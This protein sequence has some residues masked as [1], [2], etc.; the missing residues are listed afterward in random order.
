MINGINSTD[1]TNGINH[2]ICITVRPPRGRAAPRA[3]VREHLRTTVE[4]PELL[5]S[6][7][8][9]LLLSLSICIV[10]IC[11]IHV[12]YIIVLIYVIYIIYIIY[13][14]VLILRG[15]DSGFVR[16]STG[17]NGRQH[18]VT[19]TYRKLVVCLQ[20]SPKGS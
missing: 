10:L 11:I 14:I 15:T 7:L 12:V 20:T 16:N 2:I 13:I 5:A 17:A 8:L 6:Q 4:V 1:S 19:N 3:S 9:S 18:F